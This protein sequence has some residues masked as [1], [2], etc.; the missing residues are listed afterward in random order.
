MTR[1]LFWLI[2]KL[3]ARSKKPW[4]AFVVGGIVDGQ[5]AFE[6]RGNKAMAK[7][8]RDQ[9]FDGATDE[10]LLQNFLFGCMMW[11]KQ[12]EDNV[13]SEGHPDLGTELKDPSNRIVR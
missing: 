12:I 6:M 3:K 9:G 2:E 4:A 1:F 13:Q 7:H 8:L 5:V 10:E 11:P